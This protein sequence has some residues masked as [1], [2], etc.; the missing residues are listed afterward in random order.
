MSSSSIKGFH[1]YLRPA[2]AWMAILGFISLSIVLIF[3][4]AGALVNLFFPLGAFIV[5][6]IL[7]FRAPLLYTGFTWWLW[8]LTPLVRRLADW[9]SSYMEPSPILL[10]PFLVT[11]ITVITLWKNLP[12]VNRQG[13]LAYVMSFSA[14]LYGILVG[15]IFR[16]SIKLV[17]AGL[18]WLVPILFSFHLFV[19]WRNYPLYRRN[20]Q[21]VF[22]WG[23]LVMGIYG[24][25]QFVVAPEWDTLWLAKS[26]FLSGSEGRPEDA[27]PFTINVWSTMN[28]NRPFATVMM[29]GLILLLVREYKGKLGFLT[30][31]VG[32][33][34]FLLA[35]K[36]IT[37]A[38]WILGVLIHTSSLELHHQI[39]IIISLIAIALFIFTAI[40]LDPFSEFIYSRFE[41]LSN[42][43]D[44]GSANARLD[45]FNTQINA[46]LTSFFGHG[47]GGSS[48]DSGIL[49][50]LFDLGWLG[51]IFY[52]SG[53][54]MLLLHLFQGQGAKIRSDPFM[55]AA[56]SIAVAIFTQ[57]PF[58]QS[59]IG[60]QGM[61]LWGFIAMGIA[62]K[63]Y[64]YHYQN[65][66]KLD[67]T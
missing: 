18:E 63:K 60:S 24:I 7:Y 11:L 65:T 66:N 20:I 26:G 47:I 42:L 16:E 36:R 49:S 14:V 22:F 54:L 19:N 34:S 25:V 55:S 31:L 29:S 53:I 44:D 62:A 41:S 61:V 9:K 4:G 6:L 10:A 12:K 32:Y 17:I 21:R 33:L 57:I 3:A 8:F 56:R 48:N 58:G 46:A 38:T 50:T 45:W 23:V 43:E 13:G 28:S 40:N 30:T 15:L 67:S 35:R 52:L 2:F 51:T 59:H 64:S 1:L 37:W 39:R 27:G 5:G